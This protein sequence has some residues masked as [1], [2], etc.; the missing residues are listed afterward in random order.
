MFARLA[1]GCP[2]FLRRLIVVVGVTGLVAVPAPTVCAERP[3]AMKLFPEETLLFVR[4]RNAK[5]FAEKL[6]ESSTGRMARDPQIA[7]FFEDLYGKAEELYA[8]KA[9]A[10]LGISWA[11]LQKLPEGEVAFA[12]VARPNTTPAFLLLVDQGDGGTAAKKL[13]ERGLDFVSEKGG[14]FSSEKIGDVEIT[15]IRDPERAERM[16]GVFERE[17][18]IVVGTDADVLRNL[19]W[20]WDSASGEGDGARPTVTANVEKEN[21]AA[22]DGQAEAGDE[23]EKEFV[24]GRTLAENTNFSTILRHCRREQDPP[25]NAILFIDPIGIFREFSKNQ[26]GSQLAQGFLPML[27][28]DGIAGM[29][30]TTTFASAPFDD[31]THFHLLLD[32]PRSGV[33]QL[34]TFESGDTTP[35]PFVPFATENYITGRWNAELFYN[36]LEELVD[37]LLG[38]G[39]FDKQFAQKATEKLDLDFRAEVIDNLTGRITLISG[40]EKPAHFRSQKHTLIFEVKD[41]AK[42]NETL[43]KFIAKHAEDFEERRFGNVTYHAITPEWWK[44]MEEDQRPFNAYV[45]VMDGNLFVGASTILFEQMIAARDG[46]IARLADSEDYAR[47]T[48]TL[49]RETSGLTPVVFLVSRPEESMRHLYDLLTSEKSRQFIE[50]KAE[51]NPVLAKLNESLKA[52]PL[53]PFENL[54]QYFGPGGGILYDTDNGFHGISFTLRNETAP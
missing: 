2:R 48:A 20:H 47:L 26:P 32:N 44:K 11:D 51:E 43:Q 17:N 14:E 46:T 30:A 4:M 1:Q 52:H 27:G 39:T 29:G 38:K 19:L 54:I 53:P 21:V 15:V 49:G 8:E 6:R 33:L 34:V 41:E 12:M 5:E 9:E 31:L 22:D 24:P 25:P 23:K 36:R 10:F 42:A 7:P 16:F 3:T 40:Y 50:E 18:T 13:L 28:L 35:Q 45:G 37:K